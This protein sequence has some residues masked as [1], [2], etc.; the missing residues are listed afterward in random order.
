MLQ[1]CQVLKITNQQGHIT[2]IKIIFHNLKHSYNLPP[3][4]LVIS[5]QLDMSVCPVQLLLDYL[6]LRGAAAGPLFLNEE[7]HPVY[8]KAFSG[9]L[10]LVLS[11]S[12]LS[13]VNYKSHSFRIGAAS[14]AAERGF[15][16]A[17]IRLMGRWK[18]N[19]FEKYIRVNSFSASASN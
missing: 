11:K 5:R 3:V 18:S 9:L 19:A 2:S 13:S 14:W 4:S 6:G 12:G 10:A 1:L 15:S 16:D 7:G 17:Q 8:R